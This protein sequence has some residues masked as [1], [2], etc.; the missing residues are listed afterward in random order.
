[1]GSRPA[2]TLIELLVVIA[3][4]VMLVAILLPALQR[5]RRQARTLIC[6]SNL[7]QWGQVF[8][9]YM[10]DNEGHLPTSGLGMSGIWLLRGAY[11]NGDDA[12]APEDTFYHFGTK[13][14]VC[15]PLATKSGDPNH[16]SFGMSGTGYNGLRINIKGIPGETFKAWQITTPTPIFHSSYGYNSWPFQGFAQFARH[17]RAQFV[18]MDFLSFQGRAEIPFLLD[19]KSPF[20]APRD[21]DR[22]VPFEEFGAM[23]GMHDFCMNRH[24]GYVNGLFLDWSVRKVG[25]KELW[26]LY[27]YWEFNRANAWTRAGGVQ[28]EDWPEWMR[29]F[30][31]Y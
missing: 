5:V 20:G 27:W 9:T 29:D 2:F 26:T 31:D 12:N 4:I 15:C 17:S 19:S 14:I 8:M 30:K 7:R 3:I 16:G 11:L 21:H 24:S 28:P 23:G 25:L 1:M 22:P 18:E 6:Q 13:A 10:Q